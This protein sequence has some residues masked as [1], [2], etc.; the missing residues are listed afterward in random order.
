MIL[1]EGKYDKIKLESLV[2]GMILTTDGFRIFKDREKRS[3]IRRL[4]GERGLI[5]LTDSDVAGFKIRNLIRSVVGDAPVTHLYI[6]RIAGKEKRKTAPSREGTLG[7]EGMD[8]A[9]LRRLLEQAASPEGALREGRSIT[10]MDLV[11]DG[12]S[13][14]ENSAARRRA[15]MQLLELPPYLSAKA[16]LAVLNRLMSYEEYRELVS[17]LPEQ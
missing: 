1:V 9:L 4:A 10:R 3:L 6:P 11:E 13:G 12:L 2:D 5:V 15:L 14:G 7:V 16:L 8:A 17:R